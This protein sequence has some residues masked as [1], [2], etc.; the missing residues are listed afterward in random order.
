MWGIMYVV[1]EF[2][3]FEEGDEWSVYG[4]VEEFDIVV[5]CEVYVL[6]FLFVV[7]CILE[8]VFLWEK[9]G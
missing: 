4:V 9:L 2:I 1:F 5:F 7:W 6:V 3:R 8:L